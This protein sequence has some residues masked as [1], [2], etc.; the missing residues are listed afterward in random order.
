MAKS[1]RVKIVRLAKAGHSQVEI[2]ARCMVRFQVVRDILAHDVPGPV[3]ADGLA[4]TV[5]SGKAV[6]AIRPVQPPVG[7]PAEPP[8]QVQG[9]AIETSPKRPSNA[10]APQPVPV[11]APAPGKVVAD[12]K[13]LRRVPPV[14]A[15]ERPAQP[16]VDDR[17]AHPSSGILSET[18]PNQATWSQ[19]VSTLS[20]DERDRRAAMVDEAIAKGRITRVPPGPAAG[21]SKI[22]E[23]FHAAPLRREQMKG[24]AAWKKRVENARKGRRS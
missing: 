3:V 15:T 14:R 1:L 9:T 13:P 12:H 20:S 21:L 18:P 11:Q 2:A 5:L 17:P 10:V 7:R 16:D 8:V 23:Q 19:P 24:G 22:E 6:P 4:E